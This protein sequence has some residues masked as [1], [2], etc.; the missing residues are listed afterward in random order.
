MAKLIIVTGFPATG[1]TTIASH[2]AKTLALPLFTKDTY[3]EL[4]FDHVGI[5]DR[6]WSLKLGKASIEILYRELEEC[7]KTNVSV[8][9]DANF[10]PARDDIRMS[11]LIKLHRPSVVQV[12][13]RAKG[14]VLVERF[15]ERAR[16]GRHPGHND[17]V[18]LEELRPL[19]LQGLV[20][21]LNIDGQLI[22]VDTTN[23]SGVDL[24][25]LTRSVGGAR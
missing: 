3:K 15:S 13:C 11:A 6:A 1:K 8:I 20:E 12:L 19:F 18:T 14:D 4:L 7:L 9:V 22:E 23:W 16:Q 17:W 5:K 2:L 10:M 25:A 21:P 24:E